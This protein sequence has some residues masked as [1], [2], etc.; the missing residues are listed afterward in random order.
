MNQT[1]VRHVLLLLRDKRPPCRLLSVAMSLSVA[2]TSMP[3]DEHTDVSAH[4][5]D[6]SDLHVSLSI[7]RTS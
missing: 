4:T 5:M 1:G 3:I 6:T 7:A 2:Q